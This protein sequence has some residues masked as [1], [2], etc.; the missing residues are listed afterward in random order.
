MPACKIVTVSDGEAVEAESTRANNGQCAAIPT[1]PTELKTQ[2]I[3]D[4][5]IQ[6]Y[7]GPASCQSLEI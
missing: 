3:G 5:L 1:P 2:G 4:A 7:N 6:L